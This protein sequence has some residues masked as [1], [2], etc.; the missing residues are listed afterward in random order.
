MTLPN[1]AKHGLQALETDAAILNA[2]SE[3]DPMSRP[4]YEIMSGSLV[5]TDEK[6]P[7]LSSE[8]MGA[9]RQIYRFRTLC[10][11]QNERIENDVIAY[12]VTLFPNWIGF[13]PER[14]K[15]TPALLAEYRRGDVSLRWCLRKLENKDAIDQ[16][17]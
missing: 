8:L 11:L 10:I 9:L 2:I 16:P 1:L 4:F 6:H 12:C 17:F 7:S 5:W 15:P 14:W 13:L 3:P